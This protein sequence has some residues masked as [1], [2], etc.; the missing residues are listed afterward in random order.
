M[1]SQITITKDDK[2]S[3]ILL[4]EGK[5]DCHVIMQLCAAHK[6]PHTFKIY[7]CENDDGVLTKLNSLIQYSDSNR[8]I[9]AVLDADS[10]DALG[11]WT[12]V[13]NRLAK[14]KYALP[15]TPDINGTIIKGTDDKPTVGIWLMPD[16]QQ[17]GM[18]EDFCLELITQDAKTYTKKCVT[19]ARED[20]FTS[21]KEPHF[22][23]AVVHTY[24]AWQDEPGYPL[25]V[26][27]KS[28]NLDHSHETAVRFTSWLAMLF[29]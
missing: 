2:P 17:K 1:S 23:K 26:S 14:R 4:V 18:L 16:N 25:G 24:L 7:N 21:F 19:N 5:T 15:E 8:I 6:I 27:I 13:K 11:R 28:G 10:P 9:G 12:S 3:N 29:A 20:G 22:S